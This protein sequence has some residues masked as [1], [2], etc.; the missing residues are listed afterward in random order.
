MESE[1]GQH[2]QLLLVPSQLPAVV[3]R[4][5]A[6]SLREVYVYTRNEGGRWAGV[7]LFRAHH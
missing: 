4:P 5:A 6:S 7:D 3:G 1:S 2:H